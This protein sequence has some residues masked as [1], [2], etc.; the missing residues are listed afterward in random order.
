MENEVLVLIV[1][2]QQQKHLQNE[3][4]VV[5]VSG[6]SEGEGDVRHFLELGLSRSIF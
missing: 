6:K 1:F 3:P 4:R 5:P 2:V